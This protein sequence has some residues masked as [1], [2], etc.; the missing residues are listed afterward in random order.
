MFMFVQRIGCKKVNTATYVH[1]G[2]VSNAYLH[3]RMARARVHRWVETEKQRR[4][5]VH[6][7]PTGWVGTKCVVV[8]I[9]RAWTEQPM[10]TRLGVP[11]NRGNG[12]VFDGHVRNG[13]LF[14]GTGLAYCKTEEMNLLRSKQGSCSSGGVWRTAKRDSTRYCSSP[15]S[16]SSSL[17]GLPSTSSSLDGLLFI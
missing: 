11:Q 4:R 10:E 16:T 1:K 3:V 8:F 5:R 9:G 6:G 15:P 13:I 12:L 17:H 2:G 7:E 14:I